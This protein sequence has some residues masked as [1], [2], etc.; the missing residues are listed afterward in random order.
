MLPLVFPAR[1]LYNGTDLKDKRAD[2]RSH[3]FEAAYMD[4]RFHGTYELQQIGGAYLTLGK[5][6]ERSEK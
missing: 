6:R 4:I 1:S 2:P 3:K 5:D